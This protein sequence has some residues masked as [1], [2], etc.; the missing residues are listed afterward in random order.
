[1]IDTDMHK[2]ESKCNELLKATAQALDPKALKLLY[3][4]V[5]QNNLEVY[6]KHAIKE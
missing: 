6:I 2:P 1:M 3:R 5:Q 4:S